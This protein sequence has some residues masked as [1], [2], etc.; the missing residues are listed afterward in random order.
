MFIFWVIQGYI[1]IECS[2]NMYGWKRWESHL[3]Y[4]VS[5]GPYYHPT[6]PYYHPTALLVTYHISSAHLSQ[7]KAPFAVNINRE[8]INHRMTIVQ[9]IFGNVCHTYFTLWLSELNC[10]KGQEDEVCER[11]KVKLKDRIKFK[12]EKENPNSNNKI[13]AEMDGGSL[14]PKIA[15]IKRL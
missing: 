3:P 4:K 14:H 9:I 5:N 10:S 2:I 15:Q 6:G 11:A 7:G 1:R 12:S 8:Y 13:I